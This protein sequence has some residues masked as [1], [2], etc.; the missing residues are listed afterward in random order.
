MT[1]STP[2]SLQSLIFLL[3][4]ACIA[5]A[6][7]QSTPSP[8]P[9]D[10][11]VEIIAE[12][13]LALDSASGIDDAVKSAAASQYRGTIEE[14]QKAAASFKL[15]TDFK[16]Q[17]EGAPQLL[18]NIRAE[19]AVSA[20]A[21]TPT[22][23]QDATLQQLE[24]SL[25]QASAELQAARQVAA[26]LQG[27]AAQ[28]NERRTAITDQ[29]TR[30]QQ[31][32]AALDA[33]SDPITSNG[34]SPQLAD[35][36]AS[37]NAATRQALLREIEALE[38]EV[39]SYEA[40]RELLPAR[41]DLA[42]RKV[43]TSESHVTAWQAIVANKRQADAD[44]SARDAQRLRREA[45]R[46]HPALQAFADETA[47][48]ANVR[49]GSA[50][51]AGRIDVVSQESSALNNDLSLMHTQFAS[52]QRRLNASGLNRATGL[53]LR[54]HYET[55]PDLASL[56]RRIRESQSQLE[57]T[58]YAILELQDERLG[59]G[60]IDGVSRDLLG[61]IPLPQ[62][63]GER[64]EI[65]T[66]AREL[67]VARR[68]LL[69]Q[70]TSDEITYLE[71]L[72]DL[73]SA[74]RELLSA[75]DSYQRFVEE[76]I[77][78][79]RS[80]AANHLPT[81][82]DFRDAGLSLLD[83]ENWSRAGDAISGCVREQRYF[84]GLIALLLL[85]L[86]LFGVRM[87]KGV[88]HLGEQVARYR[89]DAFRHTLNA[90]V[91]T[92]ILAL[93]IPLTLI[94]IGWMLARPDDQMAVALAVAGGIKS[95]AVTMYPLLFLSHMLRKKGLAD[96]H[97]RW[98]VSVTKPIRRALR[99]FI[100]SVVPLVFLVATIDNGADESANASL[101]R[102]LFT[103][104]MLVIAMFLRCVLRALIT[105]VRSAQ[106]ENGDRHVLWSRFT[107]RLAIIAVPIALIILSWMG[108]HYTAMRLASRLEYSI[109]IA[110]YVVLAY[111]VMMRWL[112]VARRR[113]AVEDARRRREQSAADADAAR[114]S[115]DAPDEP[116]PM[117][118][119][120]KV[121][122]PALSGQ[123]RQ[124]IRASI[125][126]IAL[127]GLLF[128]W[129]EALPALRMLERV[130]IWPEIR[131]IDVSEEHSAWNSSTVADIQASPAAPPIVLTPQ[132]ITAE[133]VDAAPQP[134]EQSLAIS[135]ADLGIALIILFVT[136]IVFRNVPG[137]V[138]IVVLQRLPL[139]A[140][141]RYALS[142]V[143]RYAIAIIG[144]LLAFNAIEM[145]WSKVQ[146]LAAALTFGLAFGLQEIFANFVSGLIILGERPIRLGDTVTVGGIS[147]TVTRIRMRATTISDWDRKELVIPN[148]TFI[149]GEVINWSL[150]D[151]VLRI[152][153]PVG[154]SYSSDVELVDSLL[155]EIAAAN[156]T[157]LSDPKPQVLFK[158][159]G[160]STLDFELRV[161]IP[162]IEYI[163]SVRHDL[164][165]TI[166]KRF[167]EAGI[168]IAYPQRDLH[169][170][171]I[172]DLDQL[173]KRPKDLPRI[174]DQ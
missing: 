132:N 123:T 74:Q 158:T 35:A 68:D 25:A 37:L 49:T 114:A 141:S 56:A 116:A 69:D 136:W 152:I 9:L 87:R 7:T 23:P 60:D 75:A 57:D 18:A 84:V 82:S 128:T 45:A 24:Q 54:R 150:S 155:K 142:T 12:R 138:E 126:V 71:R 160:D 48:R 64:S 65:E 95:A 172:G 4:S 153:I 115:G 11:T 148:K 161:F 88:R 8:P 170:R 147:G 76:R 107:W 111:G 1:I 90:T 5:L 21:Q 41:R 29:L 32:L 80:I 106:S 168:E 66:V 85:A 133:A 174:K 61:D 39:A 139:D 89:T 15:A 157:V 110:L 163:F 58:E 59:A 73:N 137:L 101:G 19:L 169:V 102:V 96:A 173:I 134:E 103:V 67:A 100:P 93:P 79:V 53:L 112:Y 6:Q 51:T 145:S 143:F 26:D 81:P 42:Q 2:R 72:V 43:I 91:L 97:F 135:L 36:K 17:T 52:I 146:W 83:R 86:H 22:P 40:R 117:L 77:L 171:S 127:L 130:Q 30:A 14:L 105:P 131:V 154:V 55:L 119:E 34:E 164:H 140:G 144:V 108:Y 16:A 124:L 10:L 28:R 46:Q 63:S 120:E 38:S 31:Q 122:L 27:I 156:P 47:K 166:T 3:C 113:V 151:P 44:Q 99:W 129:A 149:T 162:S 98:P 33:R 13:L 118:D 125:V 167:R 109:A 78:W 159:F 20:V 62:D 165:M 104:E 70:L 50:S 92:L 121:D 94:A